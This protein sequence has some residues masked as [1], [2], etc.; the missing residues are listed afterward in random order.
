MRCSICGT[1]VTTV[2]GGV[3]VRMKIV[4]IWTTIDR[5]SERL[6]CSMSDIPPDLSAKIDALRHEVI[7]LTDDLVAVSRGERPATDQGRL[8]AALLAVLLELDD[9]NQVARS[10]RKLDVGSS[11]SPYMSHGQWAVASKMVH[12]ITWAMGLDDAER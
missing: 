4:T 7:P 6:W 2:P 1:S 9:I 3:H 12:T 11:A 8:A 10:R 5:A